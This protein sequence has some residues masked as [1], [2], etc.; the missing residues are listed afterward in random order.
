MTVLQ[1]VLHTCGVD[2][3]RLVS[4]AQVRWITGFA[5]LWMKAPKYCS[6]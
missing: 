5:S 3:N 2:E 1:N 4:Q 6:R